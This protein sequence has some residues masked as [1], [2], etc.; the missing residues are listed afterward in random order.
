MRTTT[1]INIA[2]WLHE[3]SGIPSD[4]INLFFSVHQDRSN[5][6]HVVEAELNRLGWNQTSRGGPQFI[7]YENTRV[8]DAVQYEKSPGWISG[9]PG[10]GNILFRYHLRLWYESVLDWR[11][12]GGV[13]L[14]IFSN[15]HE[16]LSFDEAKREIAADFISIGWTVRH[17]DIY[18]D[19][20]WRDSRNISMSGRVLNAIGRRSQG[21]LPRINSLRKLSRDRFLGNGYATFLER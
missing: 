13:H 20:A 7:Y 17:D 19:N 4:P 12:I 11:V 1:G 5:P 18:L 15:G 10:L 3:A 14:E 9:L 16:I 6:L 21:A 2:P 8:Q